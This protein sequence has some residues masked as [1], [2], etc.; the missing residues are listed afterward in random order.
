MITETE[1]SAQISVWLQFTSSILNPGD[2]D[3]C[4]VQDDLKELAAIWNGNTIEGR[5]DFNRIKFSFQ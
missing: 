4:R 2:F 1:K 5:I 3:F